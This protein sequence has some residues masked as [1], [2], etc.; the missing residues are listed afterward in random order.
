MNSMDHVSSR[1]Y[2]LRTVFNEQRKNILINVQ[3]E[4]A[5]DLD[6]DIFQAKKATEI[7]DRV[8]S[9]LQNNRT[10]FSLDY[11][12]LAT[13]A[14][15]FGIMSAQPLVC[16]NA[17]AEYVRYV[18]VNF[19][20]IS[21]FIL[22]KLGNFLTIDKQVMRRFI[23]TFHDRATWRE[24]LGQNLGA[25]LERDISTML[26]FFEAYMRPGFMQPYKFRNPRLRYRFRRSI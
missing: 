25:D 21:A 22:L 4:D 7:N 1:A 6:F 18:N 10:I 15:M 3:A 16:Q 11:A 17:S 23:M 19:G 14:H 24:P 5:E 20:A 12:V 26:F 8:L 2:W 13:T 9:R